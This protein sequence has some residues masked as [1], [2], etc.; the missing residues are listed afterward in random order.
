MKGLPRIEQGAC[1]PL[2]RILVQ[3]TLAV[4]INQFVLT[5]DKND[6]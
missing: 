5:L 2:E 3:A 1:T 4:T 6:S